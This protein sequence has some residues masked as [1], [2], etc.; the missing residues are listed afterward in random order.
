MERFLARFTLAVVAALVLM[1]ALAMQY[2]KPHY[3]NTIHRPAMSWRP[4]PNKTSANISIQEMK[5]ML[6]ASNLQTDTQMAKELEKKGYVVKK[7]NP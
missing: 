6:E 3:L 7:P 2:G 5:G 1:Q 4:K